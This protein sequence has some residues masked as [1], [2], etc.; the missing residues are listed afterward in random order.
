VAG[1]AVA[2]RNL[3]GRT[4][5]VRAALIPRNG[6]PEVLEVGETPMPAIGDG[7][8]LVRVH[9]TSVNP[10]DCY[11][12]RGGLRRYAGIKFPI[13]PGVD[14]SG[15]V[16]KIGPNVREFR[17][18]DQVFAFI[19]RVGGGCAEFAA[20]DA[21]WLGKKPAGLSHGEAGVLP[22]VG[23]T[24]LQALRDKARL[25]AG[26]SVLIVGASG[27]VGTMA[28][29]IARIMGVE[30]VAVCSTANV[31]LIRS[32]GASRVIDYLKQDV[33]LDAQRFDAVFDCVG[34]RRFRSYCE[35]LQGSGR[36]VG[37]SCVRKE[38]ID[39]MLSRFVPGRKSYQFHVRAERK[40]L[41]QLTQWVEQGKVKVIVS[42]VYPL[43]EIV[44]AHRQC[45]T[46]RTVGKI[47]VRVD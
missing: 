33:L 2:G 31:D 6:P 15:V 17:T 25:K 14:I 9:A 43:A 32:L 1:F 4:K 5:V 21:G 22:C 12:R 19:P 45:E 47:A 16:E 37:I 42:H 39:S 36:H 38:R 23:L 13:V 46:R 27:G 20:C 29:Q 40:D 34:S 7:G 41:E 44:D 10:V 30:V 11:V 35:I 3:T 26:Q 28:V 24:A 18:G 8:V